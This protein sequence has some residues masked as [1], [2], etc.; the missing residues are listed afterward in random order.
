MKIRE[1]GNLE[2]LGDE[3]QHVQKSLTGE[4]VIE[5][6]PDAGNWVSL[7]GRALGLLLDVRINKT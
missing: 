7:L 5:E 6:S 3:C 2:A 1:K 4:G